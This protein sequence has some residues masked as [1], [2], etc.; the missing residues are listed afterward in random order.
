MKIAIGADHRGAEAARSLV[1]HL[2]A[3]G[4]DTTTLGQCDGTMCDYPDQAFAVAN[5]V[6]TG[7]ADRGVLLCGTGIG[8]SIAA[9]KID[10]VRAALVQD[11]VTSEMARRHNNA[12]VLCVSGEM[13]RREDVPRIVDAWLNAEFE[14]GRHERR[15]MKIAAIERGEDPATIKVEQRSA[16]G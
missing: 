6:A 8:M 16:V 2:Q 5:A 3:A 13:T 4:H 9:N 11:E 10:G 15:I 7:Q 14:G 12:N 1:R